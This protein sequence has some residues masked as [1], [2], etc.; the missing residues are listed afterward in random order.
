MNGSSSAKTLKNNMDG[1]FPKKPKGLSNLGNTCFMNAA[2][3][4]IFNCKALDYFFFYYYDQRMINKDNPK[5]YNGELAI[6]YCALLKQMLCNKKDDIY[7]NPE[8]FHAQINKFGEQFRGYH[9]NDAYEILCY[10][11]DGILEG[12]K[13]PEKYKDR[14]QIIDDDKDDEDDKLSKEKWNK[15][16]EKEGSI[17]TDLFFG[18]YKSSIFC[19]ICP[20]IKIFESFITFSISVYVHY[21]KCT[22]VYYDMNKQP[23]TVLIAIEKD[24]SIDDRKL[25]IS[26]I[27]NIDMDC[28]IANEIK[29]KDR[30][31]E[32]ICYQKDPIIINSNPIENSKQIVDNIEKYEKQRTEIYNKSNVNNNNIMIIETYYQIYLN[33]ELNQ[34]K[35]ITRVMLIEESKELSYETIYNYLKP[36][37]NQ[38]KNY[39]NNLLIHM[40]YLIASKDNINDKEEFIDYCFGCKENKCEGCKIEKDQKT[41]FTNTSN[42]YANVS[43]QKKIKIEIKL[44]KINNTGNIVPLILSTPKS[45]EQCIKNFSN[46]GELIGDWRCMQCNT[47]QK[48]KK[49][50]QIYTLPPYFIIHLK[51]NKDEIKTNIIDFPIEGLNMAEF[52]AKNQ[53]KP[54][55][56]DLI[57]VINY[58]TSFI[59]GH[60]TT[61]IKHF[62]SNQWYL[63]DDHRVIPLEK[64]DVVSRNAVV[65]FYVKKDLN[66]KEMLKQNYI[67]HEPSLKYEGNQEKDY[68]CFI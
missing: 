36:L 50:M 9:Q 29:H 15:V 21:F 30:E 2:L 5:G 1:I 54:I 14:K 48:A 27:F 66:I 47:I 57:G 17:I 37:I 63:L 28:F 39:D 60:Y 40:K 24:K 52:I 13:C 11:L 3:Q 31:D 20:P 6:Q 59:G 42:A 25:M 4:L 58:H 45:L 67:Y 62:N 22:F 43:T 53:Q 61:S 10:I 65:L 8:N 38:W 51:R 68:F 19:Q 44:N 35:I 41:S 12:I 49:K 23:I 55:L 7:I 32:V 16:F 33:I 26:N 34:K 18:Q 64:K 46:C 56:Y